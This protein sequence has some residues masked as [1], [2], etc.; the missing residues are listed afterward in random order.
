MRYIILMLLA[1]FSIGVGAAE[2]FASP[3]GRDTSDCLSASTACTI[4]R[5]YDANLSGQVTLADGTY[6][7]VNTLYYKIVHFKGNCA[8]AANVVIGGNVSFQVQDQAITT[9]DCLT[10][11]GSSIGI[12]CRQG[13][14]VDVNNSRFVGNA[15]TVFMA[16]NEHCTKINAFNITLLGNVAMVAAATDQSQIHIGGTITI[17]SP[18]TAY[19]A[20]AYATDQSLIAASGAVV[21]NGPNMYGQQYLSQCSLLRAPSGGFPGRIS[22]VIKACAE[23][24]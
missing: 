7:G 21:V 13:G 20:F 1:F 9:M 3:I 10:I 5:A 11:S 19:T 8:N 14:I 16:A 15:G 17:P 6:P 4:Q 2:T 24:Q 22:G 23:I 12:M 18:M